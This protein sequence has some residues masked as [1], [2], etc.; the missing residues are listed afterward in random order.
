MLSWK[1]WEGAGDCWDALLMNFPDYCVYQGFGW[2]EHKGHFGWQPL[3]LTAT[4]DGKTVAMAQAL[5]RRFPLGVALAWVPGGPAGPLEAWGDSFAE[6]LRAAFGVRHL[7][8]RINSLA[9]QAEM[10]CQRLLSAGWTRPA[11]PLLSGK[12]IQLDLA[13][14]EKDWLDAKKVS[15]ESSLELGGILREEKRA[16]GGA[17]VQVTSLK[18][19]HAAERF[20]GFVH[21]D[22]TAHAEPVVDVHVRIHELHEDFFGERA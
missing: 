10:D 15:L 13:L 20:P 11:S 4:Q 6:A 3:R 19:H 16:P 7:Y 1:L 12:S 17:E 14:P 8:C 2:G 21:T 22:G 18:L 5:V 9:E